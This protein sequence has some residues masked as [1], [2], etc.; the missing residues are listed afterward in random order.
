MCLK[1]KQGMY[2]L[3]LSSSA[4]LPNCS[5]LHSLATGDVGRRLYCLGLGLQHSCH[6]S[7]VF[8]P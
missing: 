7:G 4:L 5:V 6:C 8:T 2:S 3:R 1:L